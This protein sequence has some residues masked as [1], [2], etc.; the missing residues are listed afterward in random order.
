LSLEEGSRFDAQVEVWNLASTQRIACIQP[1][2]GPGH[3]LSFGP[4]G[5]LLACSF[6]NTLV[7]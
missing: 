5:R 7:V 2:L 6:D 3:G 1:R 4:E